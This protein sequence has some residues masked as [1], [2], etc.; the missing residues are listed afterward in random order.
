MDLSKECKVNI[1]IE[2]DTFTVIQ[3]F[4]GIALQLCH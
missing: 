1:I 3:P 4:K 2:M